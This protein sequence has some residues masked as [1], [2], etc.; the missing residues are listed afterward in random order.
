[1]KTVKQTNKEWFYR[2]WK[3]KSNMKNRRPDPSSRLN[4]HPIKGTQG[5]NVQNCNFR[6]TSVWSHLGPGH[7][8]WRPTPA[9]RVPGTATGWSRSAP[10][11][12]KDHRP[13]PL[14]L[15]TSE[16]ICTPR[17]FLSYLPQAGATSTYWLQHLWLFPE[18]SFTAAIFVHFLP[19]RSHISSLGTGSSVP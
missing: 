16:H 1:M 14:L 11:L 13:H 15:S 8:S 19:W 17:Y 7:P 12:P 3:S 18:F 6:S 10:S 5:L 2:N 9:P 4:K